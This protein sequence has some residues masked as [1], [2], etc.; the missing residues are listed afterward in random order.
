MF[1]LRDQER[2]RHLAQRKTARTLPVHEKHTHTSRINELT[3]RTRRAVLKESKGD[4]ALNDDFVKDW[5]LETTKDHP[6]GK[7]SI[8]EY[9]N[10]FVFHLFRRK[11]I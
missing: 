4:D 11:I 2:K 9:I 7:E 6:L 10:R 3:A 1:V 8:V 5:T